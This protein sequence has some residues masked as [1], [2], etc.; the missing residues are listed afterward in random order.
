MQGGTL[1]LGASGQ[2]ARGTS[3]GST[4]E[5]GSCRFNEDVANKPTGRVLLTMVGLIWNMLLP[6]PPLA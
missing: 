4:V 2:E 3:G 1:V 6:G 5:L